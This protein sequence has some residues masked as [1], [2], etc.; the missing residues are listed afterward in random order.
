MWTNKTKDE[1]EKNP[2]NWHKKDTHVHRLPIFS[3]AHSYSHEERKFKKKWRKNKLHTLSYTLIVHPREIVLTESK[4]RPKIKITETFGEK[5][6]FDFS[7]K[8]D[9]IVSCTLHYVLV[10][11]ELFVA[12]T[13][14][15][16][17]V[18]WHS[19]THTRVLSHV[20][21]FSRQTFILLIT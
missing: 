2:K 7:F 20:Y 1:E 15:I 11:V 21:T 9:Y 16:Q 12:I 14:N 5:I 4:R 17:S 10:V 6:N 3:T 18:G 13:Y 19:H 8:F